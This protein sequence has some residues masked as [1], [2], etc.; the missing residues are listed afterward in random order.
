MS[1]K[2]SLRRRERAQILVLFALLLTVLFVLAGSAWD[3][4]SI[5]IDDAQLQNGV[6]AAAL[7]GANT[8]S[9]QA[10]LPA[11]TAVAAAQAT[12]TEYLR[13]NGI[14]SAT[15]GTIVTFAF[16]TSTPAAGATPSPLRENLTV[17]VT[18]DH[19]TD[20]WPIIG[21]NQVTLQGSGN[22]RAA[23]GMVDVMLSLDTTGSE[24][25]AGSFPSIQQAVVD[26]INQM[27]PTTS[28][29]RGPRIGI[30]RFAGIKCDYNAS[31]VYGG[32]GTPPCTDDMTVLSGLTGD[33]QTL[34]KIANNS[35]T[36]A[37]PV[38]VSP[39]GCPL[40]H[41][42]YT[43]PHASSY[44]QMG[45]YCPYYTGT[46][47]PNGIN[48][49]GSGASTAW[50]TANGG[51]NDSPPGAGWAR[52]VMVLMTDGQDEAWPDPSMNQGF[53]PQSVSGW[54]T[55]VQTAAASLKLGPDGV[56]GT[57]DDVDLYVVGYFCTD[58]SGFGSQ[59]CQ[60]QLARTAS[61]HPC[62]SA[63]L[64]P[65]ASRSAIDNLL[66]A[67]SSSSPGTCDR[68]YPLAKTESLPL[69]FQQLVGTISRGRLTQ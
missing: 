16:P 39:F 65:A 19:P 8:L 57:P 34:L 58:Q 43:A 55:Q 53:F 41:V 7:A 38:G 1:E 69:L 59:F 33:K 23:R 56:A 25:I 20:F 6:D 62:P 63:T 46:K 32:S 47:L 42:T 21:I 68:Y 61:P 31:G 13:Q 15:S 24:V 54:D 4:G 18:R 10:A 45:W 66:I 11:P 17:T 60:S 52:K 48:V 35:G 51:R 2:R 3:Y 67:I 22:G 5:L 9:Q 28:D 27:N 36:A 49:M 50:S 12:A 30:A 44:C 29:P 14:A 40:S 26:F 64:P 37:C